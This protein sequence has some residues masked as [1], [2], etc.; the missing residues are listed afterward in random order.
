M[1]KTILHL[2]ASS[3]YGGGPIF[4]SNLCKFSKNKSYYYGPK[5][6]IFDRI[7]KY[8][9]ILTK[10]Y[11][12]GLNIELIKKIINL[13]IKNIHLHGRG[14][15]LYNVLNLI[16]LKLIKKKNKYYVHTSWGKYQI[17]FFR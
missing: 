14:S 17:F 9:P 15:I 12:I 1:T 13:N 4:I 5:G 3:N 7:S 16:I 8:A 10:K 2:S 6:P 11:K